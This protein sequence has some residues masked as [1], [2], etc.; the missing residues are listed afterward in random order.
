[1]RKLGAD[2]SLFQAFNSDNGLLAAIR[3]RV[4]SYNHQRLHFALDY[5]TVAAYERACT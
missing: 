4:E 1:M 2:C 5:R 3:S